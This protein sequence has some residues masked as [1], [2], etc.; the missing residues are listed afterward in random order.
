MKLIENQTNKAS[1]EGGPSGLVGSAPYTTD[2]SDINGGPCAESEISS[3][4]RRPPDLA[5]LDISFLAQE[6]L[7]FPFEC[8]DMWAE[9]F[10]MNPHD[11]AF[12]PQTD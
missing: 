1:K 6:N 7:D 4:S 10:G 5:T 12:F 8:D 3:S 9:M 11:V 2:Q